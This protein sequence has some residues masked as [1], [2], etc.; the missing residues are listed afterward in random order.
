MENNVS[1]LRTTYC[2]VVTVGFCGT[3]LLRSTTRAPLL[4]E[5]EQPTNTELKTRPS[6]SR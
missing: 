4:G 1:P 6:T 2:P 3:E 5:L